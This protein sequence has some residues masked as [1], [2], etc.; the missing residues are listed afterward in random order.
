M[1]LLKVFCVGV[2]VRYTF[3]VAMTYGPSEL[4][5]FVMVICGVVN[6]CRCRCESSIDV[7]TLDMCWSHS[8]SGRSPWGIVCFGGL[9]T[10]AAVGFEIMSGFF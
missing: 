8:M 10:V 3:K 2:V 6:R 9:R 1:R 4:A 7:T 5:L